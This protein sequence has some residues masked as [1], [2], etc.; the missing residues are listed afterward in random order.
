MLNRITG[1]LSTL[2]VAEAA[3]EAETHTMPVKEVRAPYDKYATLRSDKPIKAE[4]ELGWSELV[5]GEAEP[6]EFERLISNWSAKTESPSHRLR[7][8]AASK[9]LS[10]VD[11]TMWTGAVY[12]GSE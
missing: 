4:K 6:T 5:F 7:A 11:G 12:M 3:A 10:S 2:A 9:K 1:L 8:N